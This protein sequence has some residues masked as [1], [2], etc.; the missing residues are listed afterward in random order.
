MFQNERPDGLGRVKEIL[1][2]AFITH[3]VMKISWQG[4]IPYR[5]VRLWGGWIKSGNK[6]TKIYEISAWQSDLK[7]V[8]NPYGSTNDN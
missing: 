1:V 4:G 2:V 3:V 8:L 6:P 5:R 7:K